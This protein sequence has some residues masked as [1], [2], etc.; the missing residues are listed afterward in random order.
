[1]LGTRSL[2]R[3]VIGQGRKNPSNRV[4]GQTGKEQ[5]PGTIISFTPS[6]RYERGYGPAAQ[7][8]VVNLVESN[9][10]ML[11]QAFPESKPQR[12]W[13]LSRSFVHALRQKISRAG[14]VEI[15]SL[16]P[17][18]VECASVAGASQQRPR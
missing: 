9:P 3:Q 11:G 14:S 12:P 4:R 15:A 16:N 7:L 10:R 5:H 18:L 8:L 2:Q 6:V 1:M 17:I 13:S